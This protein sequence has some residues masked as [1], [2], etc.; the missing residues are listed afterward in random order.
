[1][2]AELFWQGVRVEDP[3]SVL[4]VVFTK[5]LRTVVGL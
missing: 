1:M 4:T 2:G 3:I 5:G